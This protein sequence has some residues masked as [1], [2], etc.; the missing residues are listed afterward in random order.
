MV[1]GFEVIYGDIP[2]DKI[3]YG[4][5]LALY[6]IGSTMT[7]TIPNIS[8]AGAMPIATLFTPALDVEYVHYGKPVTLDI[9]PT[10]PTGIPTP[11]IITRVSLQ[12]SRTPFII[13]NTGSYIT[14]KIP[15][16]DLPSRCVGGRIDVEDA[17]PRGTSKKL[18][19]EAR[20]I[21]Y[22]LGSATDVVLVGES[23]PSGTTT[24]MAILQG[25]GYNAYNLVSSSMKNNPVDLKRLVANK[26]IERLKNSR[27]PFTVN[28]VAGDPLHISV[29]GL[30][31]GALEAESFVILAGGTQMLAAIAL[32]KA[33]SPEFRQERMILAT[34]RWIVMD[35]GREIT[36]FIE[37]VAPQMSIVYSY[38]DFSDAPFDGL[39]AYEEGF[40][41][42][43]VGAGGTAFLAILKGIEV[44]DLVKAIYIEYERL[45]KQGG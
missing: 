6:A 24:A 23:I 31:L 11:A 7:S 43:G 27:D 18:F 20:S 34:T 2:L 14:P 4:K 37:S 35:K 28:D 16:I 9:I 26:A 38:L 44:S 19:E 10:T 1:K 33:I 25:L 36:S 22:M 5:T 42:E 8:I 21:G 17:L 29:A 40:V 13:V 3:R 39:R 45:I 30:A 12:L 15:V 32:M 41:K